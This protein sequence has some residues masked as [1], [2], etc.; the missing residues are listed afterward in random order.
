MTSASAE[1]YLSRIP[2]GQPSSLHIV[3]ILKMDRKPDH[4][5]NLKPPVPWGGEAGIWLGGALLTDGA[6]S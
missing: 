1:N 6:A 3:H 2:V 4:T 5:P